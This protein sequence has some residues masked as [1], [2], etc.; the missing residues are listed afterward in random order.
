MSSDATGGRRARVHPQRAELAHIADI[1]HWAH[2]GDGVVGVD[3]QLREIK[4]LVRLQTVILVVA[5]LMANPV[6]A[7]FVE[8]WLNHV[9]H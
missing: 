2:G 8:P 9:L 1:D 6:T 5:V 7:H 3:E 4:R